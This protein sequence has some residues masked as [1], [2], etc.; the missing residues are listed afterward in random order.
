MYDVCLYFQKTMS[1]PRVVPIAKR[2]V[3]YKIRN[4]VLATGMA[5]TIGFGAV[6]GY[7]GLFDKFVV[8]WE[9][10]DALNLVEKTQVDDE[11][12][13]GKWS[14]KMMDRSVEKSR[15]I[16]NDN[17]V[18]NLPVGVQNYINDPKY[19][20]DYMKKKQLGLIKDDNETESRLIEV[21]DKAPGQSPTMIKADDLITFTSSK[22]DKS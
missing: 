22:K 20:M 21:Y 13:W 17:F 11:K 4:R 5:Y 2:K 1:F 19:Q 18:E 15:R 8:N 7:F 6:S 12:S 9:R 16:I 14:M 3:N 10:D